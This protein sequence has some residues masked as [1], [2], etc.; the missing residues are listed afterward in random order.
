LN[1]KKTIDRFF[2]EKIK[3]Y[4]AMFRVIEKKKSHNLNQFKVLFIYTDIWFDVFLRLQQYKKPS[5]SNY[6]ECVDNLLKYLVQHY[7]RCLPDHRF[8]FLGFHDFFRL[9]E[10]LW[11][12]PNCN[13]VSILS[14]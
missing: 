14:P 2:N 1:A 10:S 11:L 7:C 12:T 3:R 5:I 8:R 6:I 13:R 9:H 4:E